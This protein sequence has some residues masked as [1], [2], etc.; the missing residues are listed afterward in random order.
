MSTY[1]PSTFSRMDFWTTVLPGYVA[2]ILGL[3]LFNPSSLE[4]TKES[5]LEL[6]SIVVFIVAGP[7][8]GFTVSQVVN[9]TAFLTV[10]RNKY[11]FFLG[12]SHLRAICKEEIRQEL[13]AIEARTNFSRSTGVILIIL[14]VLII[15]QDSFVA[16]IDLDPLFDSTNLAM[17]AV[18]SILLFIFG[19]ILIIGSYMEN[20]RVRIKLVCRLMK[21]HQIPLPSSYC[22]NEENEND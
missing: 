21:E 19:L 15:F 10:F 8:I 11:E 16:I 4:F 5:S 14:G 18:I 20:K 12:Y 2:I 17:L 7:T 6:F 1:I 13:D 9:L 22:G 3:I